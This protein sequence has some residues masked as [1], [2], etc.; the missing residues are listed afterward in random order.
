ML[1]LGATTECEYMDGKRIDV[2][3]LSEAAKKGDKELQGKILQQMRPVLIGYLRVR[4]RA[5]LHDAEDAAQH[6]LLE[7]IERLNSGKIESPSAIFGYCLTTARNYYVRSSAGAN[8]DSSFS[9]ENGHP[10]QSQSD[11]LELL[12]DIERQ[13]I[14]KHCLELLN[15]DYRSFINYIFRHIDKKAEQIAQVFNMSKNNV[16]TKKSRIIKLLNECVQKNL[17]Q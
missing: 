5:S 1:L 4:M 6:A 7:I 8:V 15:D 16:W 13:T 3:A 2:E 14:L 11:A 12:I 17:S 10:D 9:D